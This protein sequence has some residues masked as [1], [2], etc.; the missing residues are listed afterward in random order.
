MG[1]NK[2][3]AKQGLTNLQPFTTVALQRR[4]GESLLWVGG[5]LEIKA[6]GS[7]TFQT[8]Y[9]YCKTAAGYT[10]YDIDQ[11]SDPTPVQMAARGDVKLQQAIYQIWKRSR[12]TNCLINILILQRECVDN[13]RTKDPNFFTRGFWLTGLRATGRWTWGNDT[14][15]GMN[16][17]SPQLTEDQGQFIVGSIEPFMQNEYSMVNSGLT[18]EPLMMAIADVGSCASGDCEGEQD[19]CQ[20][21]AYMG[22]AAGAGLLAYI[23]ISYDGGATFADITG[24]SGL[25]ADPPYFLTAIN[26]RILIAS[27][28]AATDAVQMKV[29][30][31]NSALNGYTA[32]TPSI[33]GSGTFSDDLGLLGNKPV[34]APDGQI[35]WAGDG[36]EVYKS[37]NNGGT[38]VRIANAVSVFTTV[39]KPA[40]NFYRLKTVG[41]RIYAVARDVGSLQTIYLYSDDSGV[42]WTLSSYVVEAMPTA[43]SIASAGGRVFVIRNGLVYE[44]TSGGVSTVSLNPTGITAI[45]SLIALGENGNDMLIISSDNTVWRTVDGLNSARQE[46]I[47]TTLPAGGSAYALCDG[48][49]H[50]SVFI[51]GEK[52][53]IKGQAEGFLF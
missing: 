7:D 16:G 33:I 12:D 50:E 10:R 37:G 20:V 28:D 5:C 46:S 27:R 32:S 1:S 8:A 36:G 44:W 53:L 18:E 3:T 42:T 2:V 26:G 30:T 51:S 48:A 6:V 34:L 11:I 31:L 45:D 21:V 15:V 38:W 23:G 25:T 29:L 4:D 9:E 13:G 17:K 40:I 41:D 35:V 22:S 43:M 47:G 24:G 19:G 39:S 52:V 14:L 49:N